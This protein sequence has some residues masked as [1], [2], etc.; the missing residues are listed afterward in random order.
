MGALSVLMPLSSG[1]PELLC[2]LA[3]N[4]ICAP[5]S[6]AY[7]KRIFTVW[8]A[9]FWTMKRYVQVYPDN[10]LSKT[11]SESV[12]RNLLS[13]VTVFQRLGAANVTDLCRNSLGEQNWHGDWQLFDGEPL[14]F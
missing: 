8:A 1:M 6:E 13:T 11:Q 4:L 9:P 3:K 12:E 5:A 7:V 2:T 14:I 10:S